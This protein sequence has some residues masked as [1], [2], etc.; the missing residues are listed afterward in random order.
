[1][2]EDLE[3]TTLCVLAGKRVLYVPDAVIYDEQPLTFSQSWHQRLRWST[4]IWQIVDHYLVRLLK[5]S[6]VRHSRVAF[7]QF[8]F[9]SR[10]GCSWFTHCLLS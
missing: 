2:T 1:M 6:I 5:A 8:C 7:D 10:L 4:G 3:I 9:S